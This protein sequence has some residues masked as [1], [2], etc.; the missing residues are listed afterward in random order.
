MRLASAALA[1][2]TLAVVLWTSVVAEAQSGPSDNELHAAYCKGVFDERIDILK[3]GSVYPVPPRIEQEMEQERRDLFQRRQ[4]VTDYLRSTGVMFDPNRKTAIFG[5]VGATK[6]G[7]SDMLQALD[8]VG[9]CW[10]P[11]SKQCGLLPNQSMLDAT[12]TQSK[13]IDVGQKACVEADP[14][15]VQVRRCDAPDNLPF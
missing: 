13:C 11:V 3:Q 12:P 10:Y 5:I 6:R 15:S 9:R 2:T 8:A 1:L 4:R 14:A 7:R